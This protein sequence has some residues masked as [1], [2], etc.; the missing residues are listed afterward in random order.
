M[1]KG[2]FCYVKHGLD[3]IHTVYNTFYKFLLYTS[4]VTPFHGEDFEK[5]IK[6]QFRILF[7]NNV[8]R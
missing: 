4:K 1:K 6:N 3:S 8:I 7:M 2:L 5:L